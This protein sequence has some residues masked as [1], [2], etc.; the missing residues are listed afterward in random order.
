V[1]TLLGVS[2]KVQQA[3]SLASRQEVN[4]IQVKMGLQADCLVGVWAYYANRKESILEAGDVAEAMAAVEAIGDDTIQRRSS[5]CVHPET[6]THSMAVQRQR[7]FIGGLE[8]GC[9]N[10]CDTFFA[11]SC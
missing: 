1:H 2:E 4:A 8:A 10:S 7:C 9:M 3:K 5:G 6:F 11:R